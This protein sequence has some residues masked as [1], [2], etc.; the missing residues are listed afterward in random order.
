MHYPNEMD[1]HAGVLEQ[2]QSNLQHYRQELRTGYEKDIAEAQKQI[3][4]GGTFPGTEHKQQ[5]LEHKQHYVKQ[6]KKKL[7]DDLVTSDDAIL[8]ECV[9]AVKTAW[10][11][12]TKNFS[13]FLEIERKIR[14]LLVLRPRN[15]VT[16]PKPV[17][18]ATWL[19][20]KCGYFPAPET[21]EDVFHHLQVMSDVFEQKG[22]DPRTNKDLEIHSGGE[23]VVHMTKLLQLPTKSVMSMRD[24]HLQN[25]I[26]EVMFQMEAGEG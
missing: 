3:R 7:R 20:N 15:A 23:L 10:C 2:I 26:D 12:G 13:G 5:Y 8:D 6:L 25:M 18:I 24:H 17:A 22:I 14:K 19:Y 4:D 21:A 11:I 1:S 16:F 9:A